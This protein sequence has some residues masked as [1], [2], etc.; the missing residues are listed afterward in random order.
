MTPQELKVWELTDEIL[1][2]VYHQD[3]FTTSD[4]QGA[5]QAVIIK[6]VLYK[7]EEVS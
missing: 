7:T 1:E 4:L 3:D 6:A 5:V 2:I